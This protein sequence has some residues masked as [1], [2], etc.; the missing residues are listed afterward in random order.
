MPRRASSASRAGTPSRGRR[1]TLRIEPA[2]GIEPLPISARPAAK[3]E[4]VGAI[5]YPARD[6]RND[7]TVMG[8]VFQDIYNVKRFSPGFVM[9]VQPDG[10][11]FTTDYST[12][13]GNSGS[14]IVSP[15]MMS[16]KPAITAMS[17]GPADSAG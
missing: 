10:A 15:I 14:A 3:G 11:T 5:G 1:E 9:E 2:T 4:P 17:P 7:A 12:L 6:S 8:Q 16:A 13:G